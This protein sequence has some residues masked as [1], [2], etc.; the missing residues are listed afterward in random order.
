[1]LLQYAEKREYL[2]N[3]NENIHLAAVV[4]VR[5]DQTTNQLTEECKAVIRP[6]LRNLFRHQS[7]IE[8]FQSQKI[9]T[10]TQR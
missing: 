8:Y 4:N 10:A 3:E 1:M 7:A 5:I 6:L 2:T 9:V